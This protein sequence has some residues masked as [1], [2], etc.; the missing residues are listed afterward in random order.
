MKKSILPALSAMFLALFLFIGCDDNSKTKSNGL[1]EQSDTDL[2]LGDDEDQSGTLPGKDGDKPQNDDESGS[3]D[4]LKNDDGNDQKPDDDIGGST[5]DKCTPITVTGIF[6]SGGWTKIN[7]GDWPKEEGNWGSKAVQVYRFEFTPALGTD[8]PDYLYLEFYGEY[9]TSNTSLSFDIEGKNS[10]YA[11]CEEC[12]LLFEDTNEG[13][14]EHIYMARSGKIILENGAKLGKGESKG[15]LENVVLVDSKDSSDDAKCFKVNYSWNNVCEP[16]CEGKVCGDDGCGGVCGTCEDGKVCSEDQSA[17]EEIICKKVEVEGIKPEK[18]DQYG[19]FAYS[20]KVKGTVGTDLPDS[21][22]L[23]FYGDYSTLP[24][25]YDLSDSEHSAFKTCKEC[26]YLYMDVKETDSA[27]TISKMFFQDSGTMKVEEAVVDNMNGMTSKSR[28]SVSLLRLVEVD[29]DSKPIAGGECVEIEKF[30]WDTTAVQLADQ[31]QT[32]SDCPESGMPDREYKCLTTQVPKVCRLVKKE[33]PVESALVISEYIH[34]TAMKSRAIEIMNVGTE[35][36][37]LSLFKLVH[38]NNGT[39]KKYE[40]ILSDCGDK[41]E[42]L[43]NGLMVISNASDA[44]EEIRSVSSCVKATLT[45]FGGDDTVGL[46]KKVGDDWKKVDSVGK[47]GEKPAGDGWDVAG[48]TNATKLHTLLRKDSVKI[49]ESKWDVSAGTD[50]ESSQWI[51]IPAFSET[52]ENPYLGNIG[53]PTSD[54]TPSNNPCKDVT[55]GGHGTC[56]VENNV[57]ACD[58]D[59]PYHS[60]GLDC[61]EPACVATCGGLDAVS[62][63]SDIAGTCN[64]K[65]GYEND[66]DMFSPCVKKADCSACGTTEA[67]KSCQ[68]SSFSPTGIL[69]TCNEGYKNETGGDESPCVK[70]NNAPDCSACGAEE[71]VKE[72]SEW[73]GSLVCQCNDGY[74]NETGDNDSP[75]VLDCSK[76]GATE[77]VKECFLSFGALICSCND[78]FENETENN[79][80]MCIPSDPCKDVT[81]GGHGTCKVENNAAVCDCDAPYHSE[82]LNCIEPACVATCGGSDAVSACS[83]IAGTCNCKDG[84]E[85]DG[86]MFS[87][88]V[89]KAD[90]SACGT[91]EAVKSCQESSFSPTGIFCTCNEGYKNES[92][93]DESPCVPVK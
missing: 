9:D 78:G 45:M 46:F 36:V 75:C 80:S 27:T 3:D 66:G 60:N 24:A 30:S 73:F 55:C 19:G 28:G 86:D 14:V 10:K 32:D 5:S 20:G 47:F 87:P 26:V 7:G 71:A 54:Y 64:C 67:V 52:G 50:T 8:T 11:T 18:L 31:C 62:T 22:G 21:L 12:V 76:C 68:E 6:P 56:K 4:D 29:E 44:P 81:C 41:N 85:N 43:P 83:D 49:A 51:V 84:Y 17:C 13:L 57:A 58:C 82:G 65:D 39:E 15:R 79:D 37:D 93:G 35:N 59:A 33:A 16:D 53:K 42:L 89:K 2:D 63:C 38:H 92:G 69:C 40:L 72:C 34:A 23:Y 1:G 91:T 90:C 70:D 74:K 48:V 25:V 77:A 88:C 61:V